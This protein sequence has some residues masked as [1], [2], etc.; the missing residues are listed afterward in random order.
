MD[1]VIF[2]EFKSTGNAELKLDR[3]IAEARVFPAIDVAA[4]GTRHEETL[5][6]ATELN[7]TQQLRR[8]LGSQ[9]RRQGLQQ[10]LDQLRNTET[11]TAFLRH[12]ARSLPQ[13]G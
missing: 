4:S 7:L 12:L 9:E 8:A 10:L 5:L 2:E 11:N 6:G 3:S 13:Q 1:T